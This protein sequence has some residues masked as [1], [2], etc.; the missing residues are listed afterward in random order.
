MKIRLTVELDI[1][2]DARD[3]SEAELQQLIFDTYIHYVVQRHAR[4]AVKWCA[5]AKVGSDNED[6]TGKALFEHHHLWTEA[7]RAR[8]WS[9][10]R[11]DN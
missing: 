7:S 2:D 3:Y 4:D 1:P 5:M 10:E 6:P 11:L 9:I 8:E